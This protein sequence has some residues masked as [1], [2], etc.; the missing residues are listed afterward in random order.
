MRAVLLLMSSLSALALLVPH[1]DLHIPSNHSF[2]NWE[3]L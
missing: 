3:T 2:N 1:L